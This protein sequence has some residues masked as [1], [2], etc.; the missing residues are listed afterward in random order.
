MG[1]AGV[2]QHAFDAALDKRQDVATH[3]G[4]DSDS[5]DDRHPVSPG[6]LKHDIEDASKGNKGSS[7]GCH[8]HKCCNGRRRAIVH[9]RYPRLKRNG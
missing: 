7:F 4:Q 8:R 5:P 3:Y 2:G 9:I 6:G 1:N